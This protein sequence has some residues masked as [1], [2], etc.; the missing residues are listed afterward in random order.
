MT[1]PDVLHVDVVDAV[2]EIPD[3]FHVVHALVTKV[4]GVVVETETFVTA[5]RFNGALGGGD[6]KGDFGWV[7]FEAEINIK[8]IKG[9]EDRKPKRSAKSWKPCSSNFGRSAGRRRWSARCWSR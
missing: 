8:G 5:D 3:E 4:G 1:P 7:D 6:V 9:V 2:G